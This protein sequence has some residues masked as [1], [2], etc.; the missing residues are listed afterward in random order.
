MIATRA[1]LRQV[2]YDLRRNIQSLEDRIR[3]IDVAAVP[4][5]LILLAAGLGIA[6]SRRRAR[7]R[8]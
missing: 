1:R 4:I 3:L 5:L 6:R 2:Q 7:A 8:S